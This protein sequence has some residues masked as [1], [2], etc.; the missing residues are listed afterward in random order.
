[1]TCQHPNC[2]RTLVIDCIKPALFSLIEPKVIQT[3]A[4]AIDFNQYI[5]YFCPVHCE[6]HGYCWAC[7]FHYSPAIILQ[8]DGLCQ[9]CRQKMPL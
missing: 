6:L 9:D 3:A 4:A 1:M 8:P 7:G 5:E 2:Q